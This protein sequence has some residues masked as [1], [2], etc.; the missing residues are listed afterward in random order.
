MKVVFL[1]P[2]P[3]PTTGGHKQVIKPG[4][5]EEI[6]D[7]W[8]PEELIKK[9]KVRPA[10]EIEWKLKKAKDLKTIRDAE[11]TMENSNDKETR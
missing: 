11:N 7:E 4:R 1:K 10:S 8:N 6:G 2:V 5:V 9:R 3:N